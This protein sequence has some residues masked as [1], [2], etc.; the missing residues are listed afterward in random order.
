MREKLNSTIFCCF[1][2]FASD[3]T[4]HSWNDFLLERLIDNFL[5]IVILLFETS[6]VE[7]VHFLKIVLKAYLDNA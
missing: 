4:L 3:T 1:S 2:Q 7:T 5:D 6:T